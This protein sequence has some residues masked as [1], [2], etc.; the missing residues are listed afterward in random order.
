M[1]F[2]HK[3][4]NAEKK[5][6]STALLVTG[7]LLCCAVFLSSFISRNDMP[8]DNEHFTRISLN[9]VFGKTDLGSISVADINKDGYV[10]IIAGGNWYKGPDWELSFNI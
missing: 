7:G 2:A 10:D 9:N 3:H 1:Q 6:P 4:I 8:L 5:Q